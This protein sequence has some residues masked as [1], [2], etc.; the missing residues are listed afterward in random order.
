M[1]PMKLDAMF[2]RCQEH[3][4]G[5][6]CWER[7]PVQVCNHDEEYHADEVE[8]CRDEITN[9]SCK[10]TTSFVMEFLLG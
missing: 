3:F 7:C 4:D 8:R 10:I 1:L 6:D 2:P 5:G 9:Q